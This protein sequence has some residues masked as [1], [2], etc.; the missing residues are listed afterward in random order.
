MEKEHIHDFYTELELK[1]YIEIGLRRR[2]LII[3]IF[4]IV[5]LLTA[6]GNFFATPI[7]KASTQISIER[8]TGNIVPLQG[9]YTFR[10]SKEEYIQAHLRM[11]KNPSVAERVVRKLSL[12]T[13][14]RFQRGNPVDI[15]LKMIS[16]RQI[17]RSN[18]I[19]ISVESANPQL[20]ATITN[21]LIDQYIE[22]T[23]ED[24]LSAGQRAAGWLG[25]ELDEMKVKLEESE[26][27]L[28]EY[29]D[30]TQLISIDESQ[31]IILEEVT[32]AKSKAISAQADRLVAESNY[33]QVLEFKE[34][35]GDLER[36][37]IIRD[38]D[39]IQKLRSEYLKKEI[40]LPELLKVYREKHPKV[41]EFKREMRSILETIDVETASLVDS[42]RTNYEKAKADEEFILMAL[43][44]HERRALE[45]NRTAVEYHILKREV[46]ANR[47]MYDFLLKRA[48][49][50]DI[51][52]G[53]S[54]DF[55]RVV[56]TA[57]IPSKPIKPRKTYNI[58]I[59]CLIG[60]V[61][62]CGT[63]FAVEYFD[64]SIKTSKEIETYLKLPFLGHIP[65]IKEVVGPAV[66]RFS[67]TFPNSE[68]AEAIR[69]IRTNI[70]FILSTP[71]PHA[72]LL[73]S[74]LPREG[75]SSIST[76]LG[77]LMAQ[78]GSKVLMVDADMRHPSLH[79]A[80]KMSSSEGL[81]N[82]L[83]GEK[84]FDAVI[85]KTE[86]ENLSIVSSGTIPHNPVELL[87]LPRMEEFIKE[88]KTKFDKVIIDSPPVI[89]VSDPLILA[90]L[91]D[92]VIFV[93]RGGKTS[94]TIAIEGKK[95]ITGINANV[96]GVI[97]NDADLRKERY[98][99]SY[100]HGERLKK[101]KNKK[102]E[103][104]EA[105]SFIKEKAYKEIPK[106]KSE[107]FKSKK[108]LKDKF[109]KLKFLGKPD[110][111]KKQKDKEES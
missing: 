41:L 31:N 36:W 62:G 29:V 64:D 75:K 79:K 19:N 78:G 58:F 56:N 34:K 44:E 102:D 42:F 57:G 72:F 80:F 39:V 90:K 3:P 26:R 40:A 99:Y 93:V 74:P 55:I 43:K 76:N 13:S 7:Y 11:I 110:E 53:L 95:R 5:V 68:A 81:R 14:P 27:Q 97:L 89:A 25:G 47:D 30:K 15:L 85:K 65:K 77:I 18:F 24:R 71:A 111:E 83:T 12:K 21:T 20:A 69:T 9:V 35:G 63:A 67:N 88:A 108:K 10:G 103:M 101:K 82:Y 28:Q 4:A 17:P 52:G 86:I 96:L 2:K 38:N 70:N 22:K 16:V 107:V 94:R 91:L 54:N 37:P 32:S 49:E 109:G 46:E 48:K 105:L 106:V 1:D 92:G 45:L 59:A 73:T 51:V 104:L 33:R 98:Y 23:M 6:I 66:A 61:I 60:M 50:T 100:Y 84:S 8:N 87:S